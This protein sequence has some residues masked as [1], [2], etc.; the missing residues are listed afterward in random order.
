MVICPKC[1]IELS[2]E[3]ALSYHLNR[4]VPCMSLK[5]TKCAK[6]FKTQLELNN[7]MKHCE[8]PIS[9]QMKEIFNRSSDY[10][11]VLKL[12]ENKCLWANESF[13][14]KYSITLD[15]FTKLGNL[16]NIHEEDVEY[17]K[18]IEKVAISGKL[19]SNEEV[20]FRRVTPDGHSIHVCAKMSQIKGNVNLIIE[21][22]ISKDIECV[23][24]LHDK[25]V[26][27][28][29]EFDQKGIITYANKAWLD[30]MKLE[31]IVGISGYDSI[32]PE[33][34]PIITEKHERY[35]KTGI[36]DDDMKYRRIRSDGEIVYIKTGG[37]VLLENGIS[38][39]YE[40]N[41]TE[42]IERQKA[43][44]KYIRYICHEIRN[45]LNI[46]STT[47]DLVTK[48]TK[49]H[50][51]PTEN[52][53]KDWQ[54]K[55][56]KLLEDLHVPIMSLSSIMNSVLD[57]S[58]WQNNE[59]KI[60]YEHK[61]LK[62]VLENALFICKKH[63]DE[64]QIEIQTSFINTNKLY[65]ID[66]DK[67]Q[68]ILV[69]VV[70][71]AIKFSN[72]GEVIKFYC[73]VTETSSKVTESTKFINMSIY[74]NGVGMTNEELKN[75]FKPYYQVDN[76]NKNGGSGLGLS[77]SKEIVNA[78][79]GSITISSE[80][81]IFTSVCIR[82]PTSCC[83]SIRVSE[84]QDDNKWNL[85][86]IDDSKQCRDV[87]QMLFETH[88]H[89]CITAR[90]GQDGIEKFIKHRNIITHIL[91]DNNMP[92]L[93]GY[94]VTRK[95]SELG[96]NVPIFGYTGNSGEDVRKHY[97]NNGATELILKPINW[98]TVVSKLSV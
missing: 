32:N 47:V 70:H 90:D 20:K 58:K 30:M 4:K 25:S 71:N 97:M 34:I 40:I 81:E 19:E 46:I 78:M 76:K 6:I 37:S 48:I 92:G 66:G 24:K 38:I 9:E 91:V 55:S 36:P 49:D 33:D 1:G 26:I 14:S 89:K 35:N 88:G 31:H 43:M 69:N 50:I 59:H 57:L 54:E 42:D 96:C 12:P 44:D 95:I 29:L 77:I 52:L 28:I 13:L 39:C 18:K 98:E 45:P 15:S 63:K 60:E 8:Y 27:P 74:D 83:K 23:R 75:V 53:S 10:I 87:T 3:Q 5:C 11:F 51:I 79:K 7:H 85:L 67:L 16:Y 61:N 94:E 72:S 21:R 93:Q 56:T 73:K 84:I 64:K 22:N 41:I 86:I 2:S 80:K 82:I 62:D 17:M 65:S 68:Q